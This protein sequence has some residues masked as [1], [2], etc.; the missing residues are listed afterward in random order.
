MA[1]ARIDDGSNEDMSE[2]NGLGSDIEGRTMIW[3]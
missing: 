1:I 2:S 3:V